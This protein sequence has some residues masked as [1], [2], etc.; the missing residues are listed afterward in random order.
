TDG[1]TST[2]LPE[3]NPGR[4]SSN[5]ENFIEFGQFLIFTA[6]N[7]QTG[8]E[9][10]KSDGVT[11]SLLADA[12]LGTGGS[13]PSEFHIAGQTLYFTAFSPV[14]GGRR[15][16]WSTDGTTTQRL[17]D[18][19]SVNSEVA[20]ASPFAVVGD[21]LYFSRFENSTGF[22]LWKAKGNAVSRV[23]DLFPGSQNSN[24]SFIASV[25][26]TLYFT[27]TT[28]IS[29]TPRLQLY[30]TD[31]ITTT[32][33][34]GPESGWLTGQPENFKFLNNLLCFSTW[35]GKLWITD[36]FKVERIAKSQAKIN[37]LEVAG[38]TLFFTSIDTNGAELWALDGSSGFPFNLAA[39]EGA[40]PFV[41]DR[42]YP[43]SQQ[44]SLGNP[45]RDFDGNPHGGRYSSGAENS[46]KY[47]GQADVNRDGTPEH[48]FT[49]CV[50][51]RWSTVSIDPIT[52][53]IDYAKHGKGGSTRV[54]G[55][56]K[57][58]LV[59][60]GEANN[61][62]LKSGEVAPMRFG[63]FDSQQR[64]QNDLKIDN[65]QLRASA[66]YNSDGLMETYWKVMDGTSYL[67]AYMHADG[68]I[69]YANYQTLQQMTD[70]LTPLGYGGAIPLITA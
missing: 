14:D 13:Y 61:G 40:L 64:F 49:N 24:P 35:D 34:A 58:P 32:L 7:D 57:D 8:Y 26:N 28:P 62:L 50:S 18:I 56:Y 55:I 70:F 66:D 47:Q 63:P 4:N 3:I 12:R 1:T 65:L 23:S 5:P 41:L 51:A 45:I 33:I 19:K 39:R 6:V 44:D 16:L 20:T 25:G 67:H 53:K 42:I 59:A 31:G 17:I 22:E 37:N 2:P 30:K 10:W 11:T 9:L 69:Q 68:N 46:Y 15:E 27:A 36:G 43:L 52:G 54:V 29:G 60:E 48:V 21:T 38:N